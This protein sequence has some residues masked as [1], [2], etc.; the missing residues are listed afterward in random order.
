MEY[1]HVTTKY[2]HSS[3]SAPGLPA[4]ASTGRQLTCSSGTACLPFAAG[5]GPKVPGQQIARG[6][7]RRGSETALG[8][9]T[10]PQVES[11]SRQRTLETFVLIVFR[12]FDTKTLCTVPYRTHNLR[13]SC[14]RPVLVPWPRATYHIFTPTARRNRNR[15]GP[16]LW[17]ARQRQRGSE[18]SWMMDPRS[19]VW[20]NLSSC[21]VHSRDTVWIGR[22]GVQP[23]PT[24]FCFGPGRM[25]TAV[26]LKIRAFSTTCGTKTVCLW[27]KTLLLETVGTVP[28]ISISPPS[29]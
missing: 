10:V 13:V 5:R 11:K 4:R 26:E 14:G 6:R 7:A 18:S 1:S 29:T 27:E 3:C 16:R 25:A 19:P 2:V 8:A 21:P 17:L 24:F 12:C 23:G 20:C 22:G 15:R 28:R 9:R